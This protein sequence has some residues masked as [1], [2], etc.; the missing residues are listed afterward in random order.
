[1]MNMDFLPPASFS[2]ARLTRPIERSLFNKRMYCAFEITE[3]FTGRYVG[4]LMK[5]NRA[6]NRSQGIY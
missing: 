3:Q 4:Q 1:M 5:A 2:R 6:G